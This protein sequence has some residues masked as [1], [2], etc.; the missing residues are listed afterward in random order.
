MTGGLGTKT[1]GGFDA[2]DHATV[3]TPH[4]R[5]DRPLGTAGWMAELVDLAWPCALP[6]PNRPKH[7]SLLSS[8]LPNRTT[9]DTPADV[10]RSM[11]IDDDQSGRGLGTYATPTTL[12][13]DD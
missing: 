12:R 4:I 11:A 5:C 6:A 1:V 10:V 2:E 9:L 3:W 13:R 7:A 8:M